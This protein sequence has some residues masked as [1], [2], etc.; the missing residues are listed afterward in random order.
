MLLQARRYEESLT[1]VRKAV[2]LEPGLDSAKAA[3]TAARG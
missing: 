1:Y 3:V 2:A